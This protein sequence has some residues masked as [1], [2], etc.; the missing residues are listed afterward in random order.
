[1]AIGQ[2]T[3]PAVHSNMRTIQYLQNSVFLL[4]TYCYTVQAVIDAN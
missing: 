3:D 2:A 1:M 4:Y